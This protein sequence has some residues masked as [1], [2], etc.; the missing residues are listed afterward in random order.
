[1]T[2][3]LKRRIKRVGI[4][5]I[6]F[7]LAILLSYF[8]LPIDEKLNQYLILMVY[9]V[10]YLIIGGEVVKTAALNIVRGQVFDENFLMALASIGA[11]FVGEAPEAVAVMLFYQVGEC[12]QSYAVNRSR[13]SITDLMDIKPDYAVV[14]RDGEELELDPSEVQIGE[15]VLIKP[16]EKVPLDGVVIEGNT[17]LNTIALTGESIPRDVENGDMVM[18]GCVNISGVIKIKVEK[19]YGQSTVAQILE[20]VENATDKKSKSEN[21][22]SKFAR[23][24]TPAVVISAVLLAIIPPVILKQEFSVWVYRALTFLV[25]SCPCA[26]VISI[27]LSFFG[28]IGGAS[29]AGILVKGSNYIETISNVDTVVLDKTGTL[30]KGVFTVQ[31]VEPSEGCTKDELLELAVFGEYFSNH[32]IAVS[33]KKAYGKQILGNQV[34][35][36]QEM[37]GYGV[38]AIYKEKTL[39]VG[40]YKLMKQEEISCKEAKENGT[41]V[42]VAYNQ[43]YCGYIVIADEIKVDAKAAIKKMKSCGIKEIVMLT[44]DNENT[45]KF[46][47]DE[48]GMDKFYAGLFPKDKVR[49][50]EEL[51]EKANGKVAF[52]GDGINDAPVL[53]RAD[54]GIAM[55]GLGSDAAI[56]A[57]D[58]VIMNDE[59]SKIS[60]MIALSRKTLAIVKENIVFAIGIKVAIL[61]LAAV[62]IANMWLAVFADV[63]VAALAILNAMRTLKSVD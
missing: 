35:D 14:L 41:L 55:G 58:I 63:G 60:K 12:F 27:P 62:G 20:L 34:I 25:T 37:A 21:F 53:A 2:K 39:L 61:I 23:Y 50:F 17:S 29:R 48:I 18:S 49:I 59:P 24:Y 40:N 28:G 10:S 38:K 5:V 16:G 30:T 13:K 47:A 51:L 57:A 1:M 43:Q 33:L 46:V 4:G 11:F 42:Y 36:V 45:A 6:P 8:T 31:K 32:P 3:K 15:I 22:I 54:V 9:I 26:L 19:E 52:V 56:E 7:I 44:G